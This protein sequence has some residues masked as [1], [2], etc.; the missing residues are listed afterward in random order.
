MPESRIIRNGHAFLLE[1][2]GKKLPLYGYMSYQPAKARYR[3]FQNIGVHLFFT[4]VYAGDRGINQNSGIRPFRPGFWKGPGEYDFS[5]VDEDFRL[6]L[7]DSKPGENYLIPRLMIEPPSW[8]DKANPGELARD[9]QGT[10]LH[11]SYCS[12]KWREDTRDMFIAFRDWLE[13]SGWAAYVPGW[14]IACGNTEEFILPRIHPM[15]Y[16]DY[17]VPSQKAFRLWLKNKYGS[18]AAMNQA[19]RTDYASFEENLIP[20]PVKRMFGLYGSMRDPAFERQTIDYYTFMNEALAEAVVDCAAMAKEVTGG[21]QVIGAF[22]GY[23]YCN[24]E[25]GHHAAEIVMQSDKIDFLASP[26]VYVGNRAQ[27][28]D[29]PF[30]GSVESAALHGKPWFAE[31]DIRTCYSQPLSK[32]MPF[33]DPV[34]NRAYDGPVWLGPADIEGSLG[35]MGKA[36]ARVLTHNTAIWWFDMWGG[37]YNQ[38]QLM[39]F[40]QK[41]FALYREHVFSGGAENAAPIAL[42]ADDQTFLEL[43]ADS[44]YNDRLGLDTWVKLGFTGTPY[45]M[46]L[47]DDFEEVDPARYR[48]AVFASAHHFTQA[49][50]KALE[51]W[52]KDGRILLFLGPVDAENAS[53]VGVQTWPE[54]ESLPAEKDRPDPLICRKTRLSALPGDVIMD[55]A[56][57]GGVTALLRRARDYSVCV[58]TAVLPETDTLRSLTAA[59]GGQI[60][61]YEGDIAYA[62]DRFVAIHAASA[63]IKRIHLNRKARLRNVFTGELLPGNETFIDVSMAFGETLILKIENTD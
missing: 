42:F 26:F 51:S 12:R 48:L 46:F 7:G 6:I 40:Q 11:Q 53:G 55:R 30:Q 19:W 34:V 52:K 17:G 1:I 13:E 31:A 35:Q 63:G 37:W 47:M 18:V 10:P 45:R 5:A 27:G 39:D 61:T 14:H 58:T 21:R 25:T 33:A 43:T 32:C 49:Q 59:A 22:F 50:L 9:A 54:A 28:V 62:S 29:W 44:P 2:D 3:D 4:G 36:F 38:D 60:Y 24:A 8:W 15:E 16:T 41:A 57:D 20:A 56:A 23:T